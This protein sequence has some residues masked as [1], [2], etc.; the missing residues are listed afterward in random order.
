MDKN[1]EHKNIQTCKNQLFFDFY[2]NDKY[3]ENDKK[4]DKEMPG[5]IEAPNY[6]EEN[7]NKRLKIILE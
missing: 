2:E 3:E 7:E 1:N 6:I 4:E 5:V